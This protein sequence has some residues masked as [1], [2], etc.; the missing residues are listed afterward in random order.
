[1]ILTLRFDGSPAVIV[2]N[3]CADPETSWSLHLSPYYS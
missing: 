1:M 3:T 2:K